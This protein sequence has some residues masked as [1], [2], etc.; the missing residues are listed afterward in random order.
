M[1][2]SNEYLSLL[3]PKYKQHAG[4]ATAVQLAKWQFDTIWH[5][6]LSPMLQNY[7]D[8]VLFTAKKDKSST[9][10]VAQVTG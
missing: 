7:L 6:S 8:L 1:Q 3:Q 2:C 9:S 4:L 5:R 10:H